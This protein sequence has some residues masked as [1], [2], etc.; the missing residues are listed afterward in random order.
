MRSVTFSA[1]GALS[2]FFLVVTPV[3]A[4]V[5]VKPN[6]VKVS[7]YQTF[8]MGV[9]NEKDTPT[10]E[11]RLVIP[12]GM[13]SVMPNVKPG[14]TITT[15]KQGD[16]VTEITWTGGSVP[17]GQRDEFLFSAQ[18]PADASIVEW[19]AYQKYADGTVVAWDQLSGTE[20]ASEPNNGP[21]SQTKVVGVGTAGNEDDK[22]MSEIPTSES[23]DLTQSKKDLALPLS[24]AALVLSAL[25][26]GM[27]LYKRK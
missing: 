27:Q 17:V 16:R 5:V 13:R 12:E 19:K 22:H 3:S 10:V 24:I 23:G 4:H 9:P 26:L 6:E 21:A 15:V 2:L 20:G 8:T 7:A 1:L 25:S 11:L 14:W 18:A